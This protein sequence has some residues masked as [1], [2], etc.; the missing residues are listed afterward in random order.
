MN[1][2]NEDRDVIYDSAAYNPFPEPQTI[3]SGWDLSGM[4][5]KPQADS[6]VPTKDS[7]ETESH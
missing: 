2:N 1:T 7:A 4:V 3:P 6:D 5:T